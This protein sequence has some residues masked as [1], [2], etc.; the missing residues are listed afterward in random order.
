MR[1]KSEK[2]YSSSIDKSLRTPVC[3]YLLRKNNKKIKSALSYSVFSSSSL[4]A[5]LSSKS[6]MLLT[7]PEMISLYDFY[8]LYISL[9][10]PKNIVVS[11]IQLFYMRFFNFKANKLLKLYFDFIERKHLHK[12]K[13]FIKEHFGFMF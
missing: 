7:N 1:L 12:S 4:L 11:I 2:H 9:F 10:I 13:E 5:A 6:S 3:F 8:C